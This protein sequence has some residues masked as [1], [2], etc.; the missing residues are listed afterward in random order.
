MDCAT[1]CWM[2]AGGSGD[3]GGG[4]G[5]RGTAWGAGAG[6]TKRGADVLLGE[7]AVIASIGKSQ[8]CRNESG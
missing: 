6:L 7:L 2:A 4:R 8:G 5:G 1:M 3:G